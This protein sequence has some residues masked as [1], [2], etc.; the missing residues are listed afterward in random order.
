MVTLKGITL[1]DSAAI[2]APWFFGSTQ[3]AATVI[4]SHRY[5]LANEPKS[6]SRDRLRRQLEWLQGNYN[7]ISVTAL[8]DGLAKRIV[9]DGSIVV[10]TDDAHLDVYEVAEEFRSF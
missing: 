8:I 3:P 5:F 9:P 6:R 1:A 2:G 7:P 4:L 10:T